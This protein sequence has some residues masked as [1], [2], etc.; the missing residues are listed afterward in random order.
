MDARGIGKV[1]AGSATYQG[2]LS[3]AERRG[4]S[5]CLYLK[6]TVTTRR[7]ALLLAESNTNDAALRFAFSY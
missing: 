6:A 5:R 1:V 7:F 3:F 2:R 4:A